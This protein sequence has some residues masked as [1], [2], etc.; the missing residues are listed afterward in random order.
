[1]QQWENGKSGWTGGSGGMCGLDGADL[2]QGT[3][4]AL[5]ERMSCRMLG[6][7]REYEALE[8]MVVLPE[9]AACR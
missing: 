3:H 4:E 2:V 1:M 7:N 9:W 5:V 8:D 6:Q